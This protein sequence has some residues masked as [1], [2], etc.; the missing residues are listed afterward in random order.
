[1]HCNPVHIIQIITDYR[2]VEL[3]ATTKASML[4]LSNLLQKLSNTDDHLNGMNA[5]VSLAL[6]SAH[7]LKQHDKTGLT[8]HEKVVKIHTYVTKWIGR[9]FQSPFQ[10]YSQHP[11]SIR[12]EELKV[13]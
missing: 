9:Q 11:T 13:S 1:M 10:I 2:K 5:A 3:E 7:S 8:T 6:Y 4:L 12:V